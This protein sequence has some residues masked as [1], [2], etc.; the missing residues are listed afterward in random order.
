MPVPVQIELFK[1]NDQ[2]IEIFGLKDG[3]NN[4]FINTAVC[5][6][7]LK[8]SAGSSVTGITDLVLVYV[9][10]SDGIY[11]GIIQDTFDP[12]TGNNY[13]LHIDADN[14]GDKLHIE[15]KARVSVR[16]I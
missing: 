3:L 15:I 16:R 7:T 4:G 13:T 1:A 12:P 8:D 10:A 9:A 6:A 14:S 11:R 2:I 5:T